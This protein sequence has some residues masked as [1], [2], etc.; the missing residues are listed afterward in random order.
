MSES[1]SITELSEEFQVTPRAMRFYE[2]K[3]LLKPRRNG[4]NR[5]YSR[6]DRVRLGL[7]LRGKRLGFRLDE[8]K[9]MLDLYDLGD[10]Q[11]EQLRLTLQKS[12]DRIAFLRR[13]RKDVDQAL[14]ELKDGCAA[15]E[16]ML[17]EKRVS[18]HEV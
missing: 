16:K 14:R 18:A 6:R 3:A 9:E 5:I 13:Q 11:V 1:Y 4:L 8:I 12:R 15:I 17:E 7:I 2:D 10:G